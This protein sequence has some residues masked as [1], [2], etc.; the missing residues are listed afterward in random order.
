METKSD[1]DYIVAVCLSGIFGI[2]G[3]HFFYLNRILEGLFDLSMSLLALYFFLTGNPLW[4]LCLIIDG[5]HTIIVTFKLSVGA[6][7]DGKGHLV[8]YPGQ[9]I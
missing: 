2:V 7:K 8:C 6:Q 4:V 1:K 5:L 9:K 3:I